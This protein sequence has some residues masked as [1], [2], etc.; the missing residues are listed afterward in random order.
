MPRYYATFKCVLPEVCPECGSEDFII[1]G[2]YAD[3]ESAFEAGNVQCPQCGSP[4]D[5]AFRTRHAVII[6][7]KAEPYSAIRQ[8]YIDHIREM[9]KE[10]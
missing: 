5:L 8:D 7:E 10:R 3:S 2:F 1:E 4:M 6:A 9:E